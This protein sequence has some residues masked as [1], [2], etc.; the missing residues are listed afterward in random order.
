MFRTPKSGIQDRSKHEYFERLDVDG[1]PVWT[2]NLSQ[3]G[4]ILSRPGQ[5]HWAVRMTYNLVVAR[6]VLTVFIDEDG[7]L[8]LYEGRQPWGPWNK[9][10]EGTLAGTGHR[11]GLSFVNK[12]GWLSADGLTWW[13][14]FSGLGADDAFNVIKG[15]LEIEIK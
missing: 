12:P 2:P 11:F 9:F 6:Y 5:V 8:A 1:D 13:S 14:V 3:R 10:Y 4:H 15:T 7:T